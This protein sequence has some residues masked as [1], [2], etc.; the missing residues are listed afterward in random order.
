MKKITAQPDFHK[1][2]WQQFLLAALEGKHTDSEYVKQKA[3]EAYEWE[4]REKNV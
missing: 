2:A 1:I 4:L 3:Y